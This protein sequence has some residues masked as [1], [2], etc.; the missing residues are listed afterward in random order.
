MTENEFPTPSQ[1]GKKIYKFNTW[2]SYRH[3]DPQASQSKLIDPTRSI[4]LFQSYLKKSQ[5]REKKKC[6][7]RSIHSP[8]LNKYFGTLLYLYIDYVSSIMWLKAIQNTSFPCYCHKDLILFVLQP[9]GGCWYPYIDLMS[10]S[11]VS[12]TTCDP[13]L[14][15]EG[16]EKKKRSVII[17]M[18]E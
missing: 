7:L 18:Q 10:T 13:L 16:G 11:N 4:I 2:Q 5:K 9:E 15:K 6:C 1:K 8:A 14:Q 17:C 3:T 12:Q